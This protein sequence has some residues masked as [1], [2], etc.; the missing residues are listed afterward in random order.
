MLECF[1]HELSNK[2]E[3][4]IQMTMS[5]LQMQRHDNNIQHHSAQHHV[6]LMPPK[7]ITMPCN[8]LHHNQRKWQDTERQDMATQ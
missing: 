8:A 1:E 5:K 2:N 4:Q 3:A 7:R 6:R